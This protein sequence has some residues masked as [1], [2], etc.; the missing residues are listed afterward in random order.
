VQSETSAEIHSESD[1]ESSDTQ[2]GLKRGFKVMISLWKP[3]LGPPKAVFGRLWNPPYV[4]STRAVSSEPPARNVRPPQ[5]TA[6]MPLQIHSSNLWSK[7]PS[8]KINHHVIGLW[9]SKK[10][11]PNSIVTRRAT[12]RPQRKSKRVTFLPDIGKYRVR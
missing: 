11:R 9:S 8:S 10:K 7:P 4:S 1:V 3:K 6:Q 5:R 2:G 12:H